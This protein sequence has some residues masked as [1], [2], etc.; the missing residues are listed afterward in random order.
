MSKVRLSDIAKAADVSVTAVSRAMNNS[1]YVADDVRMRIE[2]VAATL[3]YSHPDHKKATKRKNTIGII[4]TLGTLSPFTAALNAALQRHAAKAGYYTIQAGDG[5]LDNDSLAYHAGQ[6]SKLNICGLLISTFLAESLNDETRE[7]LHNLNIPIVFLERADGCN[8]FNR[9]LVD[10]AIGTY[11]AT[12]HLI[13]KG[14]RHL[15]YITHSRITSVESKKTEGFRRAIKEVDCPDI[16]STIT[17]CNEVTP[18]AAANAMKK[19]LEQDPDITGIV[20]WTDLF[21]SGVQSVFLQ[22]G[23]NISK[24]IEIISYDNILAPF[25]PIPVSSVAMPLDEIA[26]SAVEII[27]KYLTAKTPPSPRTITLEPRLVLVD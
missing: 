19:A 15:A 16:V 10:S 27:D 18:I 9:V 8:G 5:M 3:G 2:Q 24:D 20:T 14:H 25:L 1:G 13:E 12:K 17:S 23:R 21:A 4:S 22:A 7:L 11:E 6:L 26:A